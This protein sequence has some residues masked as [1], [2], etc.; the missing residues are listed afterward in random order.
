[1]ETAAKGDD[2]EQ[3]LKLVADLGTKVD[4][5][6]KAAEELEK[7]KK[8]YEDALAKVQSKLTEASQCSSYKNDKLAEL[9]ASIVDL[10]TRM[11][12][13][14]KASDY[15]QALQI[16]NELAPKVDEKLAKVAEL[17][18]KKAE[19]DK[20]RAALQPRLTEAST[21]KHEELADLDKQIADMTGQLDAA[22]TAQDYDQAQKLLADLTKKVDEKLA[23]SGRLDR[24]ILGSAQKARADKQL[25]SLSEDDRKRFN[26]LADAATPEELDYLNKALASKY[27]MSDIEAFDK[28]IHGKES[29]WLNDNLKLTGDSNGKGIQQQWSHSCNATTV[30]AVRGQLDPIY[31]LKMHED[32]KDIT[33]VDKDDGTKINPKMAA[34]QKGKLESKYGGT[35]SAGKAVDINKGAQG[36]GRWGDDLMNNMTDVTGVQYANKKVDGTYKIDDAM[37]DIDAGIKKGNPVPIVIGSKGSATAYTHYV[38]VTGS[39]PGPPKTYTIHDVGSGTTVTR[40]EKEV[41]EGK[42]NLSGSTE[43]HALDNPSNP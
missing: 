40:T 29:K 1:M 20:G 11:E 41:K 24:K 39:D 32:N 25:E 8:E 36:S 31:S 6:T 22:A 38:L 42:I 27:S 15:D 35:G 4:A 37:K 19:Y 18:A 9:D 13:A 5:Y 33:A 7:K 34:D 21:C 14:A 12:A 10:S 23:E 2:Y 26:K 28:K 30:E 3:A 16:L 43:I 17:D